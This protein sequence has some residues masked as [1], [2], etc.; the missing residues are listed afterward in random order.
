MNFSAVPILEPI[1]KSRLA[2]ARIELLAQTESHILFTRDNFIAL[3]ERSSGTVGSTGMLTEHGLAYLVW[4][5]GQAYL[6]S[7]SAEVIATEEQVTAIRSFSRDLQ[8]AMGQL[9]DMLT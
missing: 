5:D 8:S 9:P 1:L 2:A 7:K 6:K 3:I 4:R